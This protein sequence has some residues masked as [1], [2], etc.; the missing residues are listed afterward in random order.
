VT[1]RWPHHRLIVDNLRHLIPERHGQG[2]QQT[3]NRRAGVYNTD[4]TDFV[5]SRADR[6]R[7]RVQPL[8]VSIVRSNMDA[9]N[10]QPRSQQV[11]Q[12]PTS[13]RSNSNTVTGFMPPL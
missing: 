4:Q 10:R 6:P 5:A 3:I 2:V 13:P 12:S 8:V 9:G 7:G 11:R 1:P